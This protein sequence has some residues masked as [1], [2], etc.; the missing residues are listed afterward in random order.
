MLLGRGIKREVEVSIQRDEDEDDER[1]AAV[2]APDGLEE[3]GSA[4]ERS[5]EVDLEAGAQQQEFDGM[6][7]GSRARGAGRGF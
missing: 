6:Q 2:R 7:S 5:W 4:S 3:D 1:G